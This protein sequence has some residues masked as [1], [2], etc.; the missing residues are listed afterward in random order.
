MDFWNRKTRSRLF[1]LLL[2]LSGKDG[3]WASCY[4]SILVNS[5]HLECCVEDSEANEGTTRDSALIDQPCLP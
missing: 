2:Q 5:G 4:M 1:F 3:K